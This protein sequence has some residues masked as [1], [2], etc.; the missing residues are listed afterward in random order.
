MTHKRTQMS[1]RTIVAGLSGGGAV[2]VLPALPLRAQALDLDDPSDS[3]Y[4]LVK[5]R[6][7]V[8]G[9]R[10]FIWYKGSASAVLPGEAP[11]TMFGFQT[12]IRSD[13]MPR[14]DGAYQNN[15]VEMGFIADLATGQ[16]IAEFANPVTGETVKTM[17]YP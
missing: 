11:V 7:S 8:A 13:W 2:S 17:E 9:G 15:S 4:A 12:V 5:L 6:G 16:P 1:R 3:L 10:V 14:P